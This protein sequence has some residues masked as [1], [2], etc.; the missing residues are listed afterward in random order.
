MECGWERRRWRRLR[1]L[2]WRGVVAGTWQRRL[3]G[4]C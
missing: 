1:W 4:G 3:K 2:R